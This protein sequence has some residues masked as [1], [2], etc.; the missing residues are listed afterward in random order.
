VGSCSSENKHNIRTA[1]R[2]IKSFVSA[3]SLQEQR[4]QLSKSVL[5]ASTDEHCSCTSESNHCRKRAATLNLFVY[6]RRLRV[7]RPQPRN[8]TLGSSPGE[9]VFFSSENKHNRRTAPTPKL[10]FFRRR[11]YRNKRHN[12]ENLSCF[13]VPVKMIS[14]AR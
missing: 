4:Q 11:C 3:G 12:P 1:R 14:V 8:A 13:R 9:D 10:L 2:R 7:Q 5:G 6:T